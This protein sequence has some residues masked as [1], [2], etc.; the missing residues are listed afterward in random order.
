LSDEKPL[1]LAEN[2]AQKLPSPG[3][4]VGQKDANEGSTTPTT[5][6]VDDVLTCWL[7]TK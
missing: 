5:Q 1:P 4:E 6:I 2:L 7:S 3:I